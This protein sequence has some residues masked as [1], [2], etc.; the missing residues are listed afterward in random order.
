MV[1]SAPMWK[2]FQF[3][4]VSAVVLSNVG[5]EWTPNPIVAGGI[6]ILAAYLATVAV[7]LLAGLLARLRRVC[8]YATSGNDASSVPRPVHGDVAK[9]R[10]GV[11]IGQDSR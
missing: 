10:R 5:Y 1:E 8:K 2:L 3:A 4:I 11:R 7:M 9:Q 6:G